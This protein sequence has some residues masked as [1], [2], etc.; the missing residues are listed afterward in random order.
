MINWI[1]V[2]AVAA[3]FVTL[4][5]PAA[6]ADEPT[7][8]GIRGGTFLTVEAAKAQ[9]DKGVPFVDARVAAE[10]AEKHIKGAQ[11]I[12]YKEKFPRMSKVDATDSFDVGKVPAGP[13]V[14]YCNGSPCWKAFK[15]A[16]AA[17]KAGNKQVFWLRDGIP[18]WI[19]KGFPTE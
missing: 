7:P 2:A 10:Y 9:F 17:I 4:A 8:D 11:S 16:S 19:A 12:P 5:A 1:E 13:V 14:F 15:A 6:R 18:A 3:A